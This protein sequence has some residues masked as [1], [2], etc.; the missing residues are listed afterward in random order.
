MSVPSRALVISVDDGVAIRCEPAAENSV[1]IIATVG[2]LNEWVPKMT[3]GLA[4]FV[5]RMDNLSPSTAVEA[6]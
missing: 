4:V 6:A 1:T 2:T 3:L 5:M